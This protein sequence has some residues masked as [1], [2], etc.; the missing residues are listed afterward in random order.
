[1]NPFNFA[2]P[3]SRRRAL[4]LGAS[5][6][7]GLVAATSLGRGLA[8]AE[9]EDS[10]NGNTVPSQDTRSD[11]EQIIGA[12][13]SVSDGVFTIEIDRDD[14]N[15][16]T[17]H[18]VPIKPSFQING[19]L[20]FQRYG[21]DKVIMNSDLCLKPSELDGFLQQLI[22]HDIVFQAEHQHMYDY[23]PIVWF[24]HFRAY[25]DPIQIA[26]GVKAALNATST[27]FPQTSPSDPTTPLPAE[28]IG[29]ILGASPSI[30]ADGVVTYQVPRAERITLGGLKV[31]PYLNVAAPIA[32]QPYGGGQNAAAVPDFAMIASEIN[33]VIKLMLKQGWDIGCLYNQET[34]E[35]PQLYFSHNF[36]TGDSIQLAKEIR[37]GLNLTNSKFNS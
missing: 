20:V 32:F 7:G 19:D 16:V 6:T 17:L 26:K 10:D 30:G 1:M 36:K 34:D 14:I 35:H 23:T 8:F 21:R 15:N 31:N 27:P 22:A 12:Q 2:A 5:L 18:G 28:E 4:T 13:G 33:N 11:I 24:V 3:L 9:D 25:G 37:N 29:K